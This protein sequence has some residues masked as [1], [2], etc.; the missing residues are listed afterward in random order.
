LK[1]TFG[2]FQ[3]N[4]QNFLG[5]SGLNTENTDGLAALHKKQARTRLARIA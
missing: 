1:E 3:D 5:E 2:G 4:F